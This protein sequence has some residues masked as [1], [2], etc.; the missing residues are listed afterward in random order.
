MGCIPKKGKK[1]EELM[2]ASV[3]LHIAFVA[4]M[5]LMACFN[6]YLIVKKTEFSEFSKKV[7][8]IAPL[9]YMIMA[10]LIFTGLIAMG[11]NHMALTLHVTLMI[12]AW[13]IIFILSMKAYKKYKKTK[14]NPRDTAL[15]S[16]YKSFAKK[17]YI[18]DISLM[19]LITMIT[20]LLA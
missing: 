15:Q 1:M 4:I 3:N 8:S 7:H 16:D 2:S 17:K 12:I 9:Y 10:A 14:I 20:Y 5:I 18:I 6:L 19:I 13:F 11:V